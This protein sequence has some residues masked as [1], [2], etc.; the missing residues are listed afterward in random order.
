MRLRS[1]V[2]AS[3]PPRCGRIMLIRRHK[4]HYIIGARDTHFENGNNLKI[5]PRGAAPA[6][7]DS[8]WQTEWRTLS[9]LVD[10]IWRIRTG[11]TLKMWPVKISKLD[12]R[13]LGP[14]AGPGVSRRENSCR[15]SF[16]FYSEGLRRRCLCFFVEFNRLPCKTPLQDSWLLLTCKCILFVA[17]QKRRWL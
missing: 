15:C 2:M 4:A 5:A 7:G 14:L 8:D 12:H 17:V 3:L 11:G 9:L 1:P 16:T 10:K 6:S 13:V